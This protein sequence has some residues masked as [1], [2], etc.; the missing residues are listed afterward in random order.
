VQDLTLTH[1]RAYAWGNIT[2]S[3]GYT[4]V[5]A[6]GDTILEDG[7]RGFVSWRHEIR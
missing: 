1:E 6:S 5:D 4:D 3:L 7:V 2:L